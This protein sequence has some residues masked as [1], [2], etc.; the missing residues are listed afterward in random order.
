MTSLL[1][2]S[3]RPAVEVTI[4]NYGQ[5]PAY[6][7]THVGGIALGRSFDTLPPPTEPEGITVSSLPPG[8]ESSSIQKGP[9]F[10]S[11]V[12]DALRNGTTTFGVYGEIRYRDAFNI[13][14]FTNYRF[15][16]GGPVG[17]QGYR[18]AIC[19]E[20]NEEN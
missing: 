14:R 10:S 13:Q 1:E 3:D 5:T 4:K 20:W 6:A 15:M 16:T 12:I 8:G 19:E 2:S 7:L 9:V 17:L 18:L 11:I